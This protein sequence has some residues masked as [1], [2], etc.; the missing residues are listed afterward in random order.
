[1]P[2]SISSKKQEV[3]NKEHLKN[4]LPDY[5]KIF[6]DSGKLLEDHSSDN[7]K[8]I[9]IDPEKLEKNGLKI[10][11]KRVKDHLY[12]YR[13]EI[14]VRGMWRV[15]ANLTYDERDNTISGPI[16]SFSQTKVP[17]IKELVGKYHEFTKQQLEEKGEHKFD[18]IKD[19]LSRMLFDEQGLNKA[20]FVY[21]PVG[22]QKTK[23][24]MEY[25]KKQEKEKRRREDPW[26]DLF[27]DFED[28]PKKNEEEKHFISGTHG[29]SH[30][31]SIKHSDGRFSQHK[32]EEVREV[33]FNNKHPF[34]VNIAGSKLE[35]NTI[36]TPSGTQIKIHNENLLNTFKECFSKKE[37]KG[38]AA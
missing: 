19:E 23:E 27:D 31:I 26:H 14:H 8:N 10:T 16:S 9:K 29:Y 6:D 12:T 11:L 7:L 37:K 38:D 35:G 1:M 2:V 33:F 15:L 20:H 28:K 36:I 32:P 22:A 13:V 30:A 18:D 34:H 4:A 17:M 21:R 3:I 24:E 25:E 5:I